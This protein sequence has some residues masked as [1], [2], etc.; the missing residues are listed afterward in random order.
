L[1][2]TCFF[3]EEKMLS[4]LDF[5]KLC[6]KVKQEGGGLPELAKAT[7]LKTATLIQKRSSL[8]AEG[9]TIPEFRKG[10]AEGSGSQGPTE[11]ELAEIAAYTGKTLEEVKA[12]SEA[13]KVAVAK[14]A[15]S[16]KLG[17]VKAAQVSQTAQ[18]AQTAPGTASPETA[19]N[20]G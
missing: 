2:F 8:R 12:E 5:V 17:K 10:R 20:A 11:A 4:K 15:E 14:H 18:T 19:E 13:V 16:V 7:G 3:G 1:F 9:Y 6:I